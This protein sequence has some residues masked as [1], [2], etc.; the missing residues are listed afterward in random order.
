[1]TNEGE[2]SLPEALQSE[3]RTRHPGIAAEVEGA[4][5][6]LRKLREIAGPGSH[7]TPAGPG[8]SVTAPVDA[9][10]ALTAAGRESRPE[11]TVLLAKTELAPGARPEVPVLAAG[12]SFGR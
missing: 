7:A 6:T 8:P 12:A 2:P 3:L 10:V 1:M 4:I 9:T 5:N 11:E